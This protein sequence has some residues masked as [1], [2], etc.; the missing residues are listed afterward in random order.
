MKNTR[1][2]EPTKRRGGIPPR[3]RAPHEQRRRLGGSR[4]RLSV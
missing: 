3:V 2:R 1:E 4:L